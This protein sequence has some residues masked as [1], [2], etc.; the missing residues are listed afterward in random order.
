M[1]KRGGAHLAKRSESNFFRK[2]ISSKTRL[3]PVSV[4]AGCFSRNVRLVQNPGEQSH[5]TASSALHHVD[6]VASIAGPC[7][8]R[9]NRRRGEPSGRPQSR[10]CLRCP[11]RS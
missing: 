2:G 10:P 3:E 9:A 11:G 6:T 5:E 1:K 7:L 4:S 8:V